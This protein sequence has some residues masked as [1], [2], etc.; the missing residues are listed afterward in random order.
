MRY[1][2]YPTATDAEAR[3]AATATALGCGRHPDDTTRL[4]WAVILHPTDGRAALAIPAEDEH[5]LTPEEQV[6]LVELSPD[7]YPP[8]PVES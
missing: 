1:L 3:S 2:I 5:L 6:Q 7:W 8:E 4:W